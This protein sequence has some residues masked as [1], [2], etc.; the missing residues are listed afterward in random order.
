MR[1]VV[2]LFSCYLRLCSVSAAAAASPGYRKIVPGEGMPHA[3]APDT[4]GDLI[5]EFNIE[6]PHSLAP[7]K[8]S[9]VRKALPN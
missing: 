1:S 5:I 4:K 6:F 8:R 7:E 3:N 9:L 2:S